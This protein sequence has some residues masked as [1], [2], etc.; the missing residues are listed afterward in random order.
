[1][2]A[3]TLIQRS[4]LTLLIFL[5]G[6][7]VSTTSCFLWP[8]GSNGNG[9]L[10]LKQK[11]TPRGPITTFEVASTLR[12]AGRYE[13]ALKVYQQAVDTDPTSPVAA[14]ALYEIGGIYLQIFEYQK[15]M[16]TY[17]N[18]LT[19]FPSYREAETVKR[20]IE[21]AQVAQRV[22]EERKAIAT[23]PPGPR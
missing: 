4:A 2:L 9:I 16:D 14:D 23:K 17:Q 19:R 11:S 22:L 20:K 15:A 12:D 21:F 13:E 8:F 3:R 7:L 6:L 1:M 18:L 10:G 5:C